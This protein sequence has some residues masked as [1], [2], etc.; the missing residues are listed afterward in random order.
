MACTLDS[1]DCNLFL[2]GEREGHGSKRRKIDT[3]V[4][5]VINPLL[6]IISAT[7]HVHPG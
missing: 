2:E 3:G 4:I 7:Q 5:G 1:C 6:Y